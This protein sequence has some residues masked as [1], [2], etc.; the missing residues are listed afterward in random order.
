MQL[1]RTESMVKRSAVCLVLLRTQLERTRNGVSV[2]SVWS[3]LS[4]N[5]MDAER[6]WQGRHA[7]VVRTWLGRRMIM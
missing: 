6:T 7:N 5:L 2:V 1:E 4:G 3:D